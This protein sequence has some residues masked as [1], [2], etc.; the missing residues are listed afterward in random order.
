MGI[1]LEESWLDRLNGLMFQATTR[2]FLTAC[3]RNF[4]GKPLAIALVFWVL[5]VCASSAATYYVDFAGGNNMEDGLSPQ[6]AWKHAPGDPAATGKPAVADLAPGDVVILKG[7]VAYQG[8]IRLNRSGTAE[9]P[10][11]LD[12]NTA[13][14]FGT[15]RAVLD[16]GDI[17]TGWTRC[18]KP[19][20]AGGN[21]R[22]RDIYFVDIDLDITPNVEHGEVV[23]H[24]KAPLLKQ[25][26]WQRVIL[27]DG[28]RR[29]LPISQYPKPRDPFFPDLPAD[30]QR[31]PTPLAIDKTAGK[32]VVSDPARL[33]GKDPDWLEGAMIGVHGG[34]NHVYFA[35]VDHFDPESGEVH[36][37]EF[38]ASTYEDSQYAFYNSVRLIE[39]PGEWAIT[40]IG[41][42]RSRIYLLPDHLENGQPANIGYPVLT[43]AVG[44][45]EGA[46]HIR[47]RG[48]RI[49]RYAG[50]AG[51][52][53]I[54]S[55]PARSRDISIS[56]CE[57]RFLTGA[58]AISPNHC[59]DLVVERCTIHHCPGWTTAVFPNR[60]NGLLVED[61]LLVKNSGSGIRHYESKNVV[62]RNN[63]VLGHFGMHSSGINIYEGCRDVLLK[64]N[65]IQNVV[66]INRSA[67]NITL[68]NNVVDSMGRNAAPVSIWQSGTSGGTHI[69]G[70]TFENNTLVNINRSLPWSTSIFVQK[71]AGG[72][73]KGLVLRDNVL[74][75]TAPTL[76][77][78]KS[79]N[80]FLEA[81]DA[82]LLADGG[83]VETDR[84][85]VFMD[86]GAGDFRRRPG[87]PLPKAGADVPPPP[88]PRP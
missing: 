26:P 79:G 50:G 25:A 64:G 67:E 38:T 24:R 58:A 83:K 27:I 60:V 40:P 82:Q 11:I 22:W 14:T 69:R 35:K 5:G 23:L 87:G 63:Y 19:E 8:R 84:E 53:F 13:G 51:G 37:A 7:G 36:F 16:G 78:K 4:R 65:Y 77:G 34:N 75:F 49:Q 9:A 66:A 1:P 6:T 33:K 18:E 85:R 15:G 71:A 70:L 32:T 21:P 3:F 42:G 88:D 57:I 39:N 10:I 43:E 54:E 41:N 86:A 20:Q 73:P 68:R 59:D 55:H 48:L 61:C 31:S 72:P 62:L 28:D 56:D 30:F 52:I 29:L 81:V 76:P 12:G 17:L 46:S 80:L 45:V 47:V 74:A 44:I 2:S